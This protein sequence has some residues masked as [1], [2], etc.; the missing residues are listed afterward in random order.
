MSYPAKYRVRVEFD[1]GEG[2]QVAMDGFCNEILQQITSGE[3]V[4]KVVFTF[5]GGFIGDPTPKTVERP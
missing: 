2:H 1:N 5:Q 4:E 3:E